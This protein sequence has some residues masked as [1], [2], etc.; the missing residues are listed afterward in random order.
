MQSVD[1]I[2]SN[3]AH[4]TQGK[5][6][7]SGV[8]DA[9]MAVHVPLMFGSSHRVDPIA[10]DSSKAAITIKAKRLWS[11]EKGDTPG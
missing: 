2:T 10:N 6:A 8:Q 1:F 5:Y 7:S 9:I 4:V 11:P 3:V